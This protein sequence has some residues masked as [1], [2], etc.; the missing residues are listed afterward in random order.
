MQ[1]L[2]QNP[3]H[4]HYSKQQVRKCIAKSQRDKVNMNNKLNRLEKNTTMSTIM[5]SQ[6]MQESL[7]DTEAKQM[8]EWEEGEPI[9]WNG[10]AIYYDDIDGAINGAI[11]VFVGNH[12]MSNIEKYWSNFNY[13]QA[14]DSDKEYLPM[15][16]R[17]SQNWS[18]QINKFCID[19]QDGQKSRKI[20]RKK[21]IKQK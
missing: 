20:S 6:G 5:H 12:I 8:A 4:K 17:K 2:C 14:T 16:A 10:V 21:M 3:M 7:I 9:V 18:R 11:D 13:F 15:S 19:D 1:H